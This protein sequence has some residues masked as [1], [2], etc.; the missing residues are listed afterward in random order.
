MVLSVVPGKLN[1]LQLTFREEPAFRE[2]RVEHEAEQIGK[3]PNHVFLIPQLQIIPL[4][5]E[6]IEGEFLSESL[7]GEWYKHHPF[8]RCHSHFYYSR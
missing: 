5:Q 1:G 3:S 2:G 4:L 6:A 7:N 8:F